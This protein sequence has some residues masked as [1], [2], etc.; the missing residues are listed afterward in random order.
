V[1]EAFVLG[2]EEWVGLP[3]LDLPAIKAKVDTGAKT[4]S[5]HAFFVEPFGSASRPM[6]RFGVHPIP[7]R[8]DVEVICT[9]EAIDHREV[10]SSNGESEIRYVIRTSLKLG[11]RAWPIELTLTNRETMSYRMLI[12]R[13]AIQDD[14]LVDP[15]TSFRQ[16]RLSY[17]RYDIPTRTAEDRRALTIG[18][19]TRRPDNATNRR[20]QRVAERRGHKLVMIDRDRVSLF[21]DT[22]DPAILLDGT[23]ATHCDAVI[24]RPGRGTPTFSAAVARQFE[25]LGAVVINGPDALLRIADPLSTR[26]LLARAGLPVPAAAVSSAATNPDAADRH[27]LA[28]GFGSRAPGTLVRHTIVGSRA[29]AAMSRDA[30]G[31]EAIDDEA[32]WRTDDAAAFEETRAVAE[33]AARV[34]GLEL[35]G[36]DVVATRQGPIV[37]GVTVS[38]AI[39][40]AERITGAAISEAIVIYIEQSARPVARN[41]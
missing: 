4:S 17:R 36:V 18:L 11:E 6:V 39:S 23:S 9:A 22:S 28:D 33:R 41:Q 40:L 13:Q 20:I 15:A 16:P 34:L 5:L 35:A 19:L 32:E 12:G 30:R 1:S 24:V 31:D 7:G 8:N 3:D 29:V 10:T 38:P 37:V 25:T 2:W 27:V 14:M 26:Q 21:I